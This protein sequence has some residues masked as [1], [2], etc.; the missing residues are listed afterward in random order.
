MFINFLPDWFASIPLFENTR[1]YFV[2][3]TFSYGDMAAITIG[4][5]AAY[6]VLIKISEGGKQQTHTGFSK[7]NRN[8]LLKKA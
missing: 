2:R 3:G 8:I 6:F 7:C 1:D 4:T 5:V